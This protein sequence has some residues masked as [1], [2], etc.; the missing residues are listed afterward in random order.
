MYCPLVCL[1][2]VT[3]DLSLCNL[4][5]QKTDLG[6]TSSSKSF[7]LLLLLTSYQCRMEKPYAL[8]FLLQHVKPQPATDGRDV[9]DW[10]NLHQ[11]CHV[12]LRL[13]YP[14]SLS[15]GS[16]YRAICVVVAGSVCSVCSLRSNP[17]RAATLQ[18]QT[19]ELPGAEP[20]NSFLHCMTTRTKADEGCCPTAE[21]KE[22]RGPHLIST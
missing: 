1:S 14:L 22:F 11:P 6:A 21:T 12:K 10:L 3:K 13:S 19:L 20:C 17:P 18:E 9:Q 7:A 2:G 8:F 4:I 15:L 16:S 5:N